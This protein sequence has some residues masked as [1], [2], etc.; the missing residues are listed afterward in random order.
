MSLEKKV[1]LVEVCTIKT[2]K[3]DVNEEDINGK[4]PFFTCAKKNTFSSNYSFDCEAILIAGNGA[5]G[6][7]S[8]YSGKFEAYQRTYVLSEFKG[9]LPKL[10]YHILNVRLVKYL[11]EMVLGNTIPYIKVGMLE[12]FEFKIPSIEKQKIL[13][14]KIESTFNY[15][16]EEVS[17]IKKNQKKIDT[18]IKQFL[19]LKLSKNTEE[20]KSWAEVQLKDIAYTA[21]RIGWKGLS[22]KE[23]VEKGPLFL[24]VHSLNHGDYVDF[25]KAFHIT[26]KRYDESPEIM[27][28]SDDILI[29]KDGAGI[30]K[31]GIVKE[32]H[33]PTTINGSLLLIRSLDNV[34]PKYLYYY[35]I[36]PMFQNIVL[37]RIEGT[38]TPHLYQREIK[39]F[40][41]N[42]PALNLQKIKIAKIEKMFTEA[43]T[44]K[45]NYSNTI[46]EYNKLKAAI[47]LK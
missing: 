39:T 27:L 15:I 12:N 11:S 43:N 6:Q 26:K 32:I 20:Q 30:G 22:A 24:S 34:L 4:F 9:I 2:G 45:K 47:I 31:V 40:P 5:V 41:I 16:D 7:T 46:N 42:F 28:K 25:S 29:C 21:G 13:L 10:L 18:F 14:K 23:Y 37:T 35:L 19:K 38:T 36:S 44:L 17:K 8:Y 1:K 3:K 33:E